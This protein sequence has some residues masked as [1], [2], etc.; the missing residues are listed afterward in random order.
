M[1]LK[2][3]V[4]AFKALMT[5]E[6]ARTRRG[7]TRAVQG[8]GAELQA[9]LRADTQAAGLGQGNVNAWRQRTWPKGRDSLNAAGLVWSRAPLVVDG[10]NRGSLIRTRGG[11]FLAVPTG[12]N[13][14]D[15][16]RRAKSEGREG[17]DHW[18]GVRVKPAEMIASRL[19][20]VRRTR[21]PD[22]LLWCLPV[23]EQRGTSRKGR[24]TRK[25]LA[26][27][28]LPVGARGGARRDDLLQQGFVP[29]FLLMPAT[30]LD[31]RLDLQGRAAEAEQDL[32]RR[33]ISEL[34]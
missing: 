18:A 17:R 22:V 23:A 8:A 30:K 28:F 16:R 2:V 14:V 29:M 19:A 34:A 9:R 3:E 6:I 15:G 10:F 20:F 21:R 5:G 26:G 25:A 4:A 27:G 31:K 13:R 33:L 7:V 24:Q 1:R 32:Q 12:Y 11:R